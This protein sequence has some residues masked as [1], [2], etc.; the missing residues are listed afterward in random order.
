MEDEFETYTK[1]V[2]IS[3]IGAIIFSFLT[4]P[5]VSWFCVI[6]GPIV[7]LSTAVGC[8][9]L[10]WQRRKQQPDDEG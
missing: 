2:V 1:G 6:V 4:Y 3:V 5:M 8:E 10:P 9:K 7:L